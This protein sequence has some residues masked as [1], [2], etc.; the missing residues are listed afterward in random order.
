MELFD[1]T[2]T[3]FENPQQWNDVSNSDKKKH[4]FISN[5]MFSIGHPLQ[6][7]LLQ[8]IKVNPAIIMDIWQRLMTNKFGYKKTPG[9]MFTKGVV[10]NKLEKEKKTSLSEELIKEY[11]RVY[12]VD[13]KSIK[14]SLMFFHEKTVNEI[15]EFEKV[16]KQK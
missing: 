3:L 4:F 10:K 11:C 13:Y 6:A 16:I 15:K 5:R 8:H 9:W 7:H 12:K 2:K 1:L 14:D